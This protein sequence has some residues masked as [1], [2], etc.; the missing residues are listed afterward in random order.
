MKER[1]DFHALVV[2]NSCDRSFPLTDEYWYRNS[3][4]DCGFLTQCK[5]CVNKANEKKSHY[6][7]YSRKDI[8]KRGIFGAKC[9]F[10]SP[11]CETCLLDE[12]V[13]HICWRLDGYYPIDS[14][15]PI[16]K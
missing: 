10:W 15:Y 8:I 7:K 6:I 13:L 4:S 2:C 14:E 16:R 9:F 3:S 11:R 12:N 1:D 5:D